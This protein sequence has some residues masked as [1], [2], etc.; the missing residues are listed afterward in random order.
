MARRFHVQRR[1]NSPYSPA[2]SLSPQFRRSWLRIQRQLSYRH[3]L[4]RLRTQHRPDV[5]A[6]RNKHLRTF[7]PCIASLSH[8]IRTNSFTSLASSGLSLLGGVQK[9]PPFLLPP[10]RL[11]RP[12]GAHEEMSPQIGEGGAPLGPTNLKS[13]QVYC[14]RGRKRIDKMRLT[15]ERH[16]ARSRHAHI[17]NSG[18]AVS[19]TFYALLRRGPVHG[20]AAPEDVWPRPCRPPSEPLGSHPRQPE[21]LQLPYCWS[22]PSTLEWI[23]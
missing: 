22:L 4:M 23:V 20:L 8:T 16:G 5:R 13:P 1:L 9:C 12:K 2:T 18:S 7:Q 6:M 21:R 14:P 11:S 10:Q 19:N 17:A 3:V 15:L